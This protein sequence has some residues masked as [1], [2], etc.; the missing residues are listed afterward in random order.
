MIENGRIAYDGTAA[1]L[2]EHPEKLHSA[3]L[4]REHEAAPEITASAD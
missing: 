3:Y 4:L 2:K 1:D